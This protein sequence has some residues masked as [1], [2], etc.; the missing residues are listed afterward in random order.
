[1]GIYPAPLE[2]LIAHLCK[3][4]GIGQKS[5]TRMALYILRSDR[6]QAEDLASALLEVKEK[7]RFCSTCFNFTD[8]DPCSI[9]ADPSR[10]DG[11]ICVVEGPGDQLAIEE[12]GVFTGRYH[13]LQGVLSPLDGI[14]PEDLK[15]SELLVRLQKEDIKEVILATNPTTEGEATASFLAQLIREKRPDI[16]VTRIALGVPMGGDLK[17]MDKMT[18]QRALNSRISME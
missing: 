1:M 13:V 10:A 9:C 11:R 16:K 17:Y 12:S 5:A 3:L 7:I 14:G 8:D 18:L 2:K 4:P 15:I 6:E